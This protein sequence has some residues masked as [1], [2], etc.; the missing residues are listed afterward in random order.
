MAFQD[1]LLI[2]PTLHILSPASFHC[3]LC[4]NSESQQTIHPSK[5]AVS[6]F[7]RAPSR[8]GKSG[9]HDSC[10][11]GVCAGLRGMVGRWVSRPLSFRCL[12]VWDT[13]RDRRGWSWWLAWECGY[14]L[15]LVFLWMQIE[16]SANRMAQLSDSWLPQRSSVKK[17]Q[18]QLLLEKRKLPRGLETGSVLA[19]Y[20]QNTIRAD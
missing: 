15:V 7:K 11:G 19:R 9:W 20:Y 17:Q 8:F 14:N 6:P 16:Q 10:A 18:T 5:R 4:F 1:V 13:T 12:C 3:R 2:P